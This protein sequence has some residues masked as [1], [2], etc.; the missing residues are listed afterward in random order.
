[1]R[2]EKDKPAARRGKERIG[3]MARARNAATVNV[4]TSLDGRES[5]SEAL[6]YV[7]TEQLV[8]TGSATA[9]GTTIYLVLQ[10]INPAWEGNELL[11]LVVAVAVSLG[12]YL[13][14]VLTPGRDLKTRD[15]V[16][17]LLTTAANS[18]LLAA[19]ILGINSI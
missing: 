3:I 15:Y 17:R 10:R 12:Y 5:G 13:V 9:L 1:V 8:N 18:F 7:T 16:I 14:D 19:A 2:C 4:R 11:A 6:S